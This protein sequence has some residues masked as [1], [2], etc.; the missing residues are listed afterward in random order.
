MSSKF[1][2]GDCSELVLNFWANLSLGILTKFVLIKKACMNLFVDLAEHVLQRVHGQV[3]CV[4]V[5]IAIVL[6][7]KPRGSGGR[8]VKHV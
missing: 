6:L 7:C 4:T 2:S 1:Q 5:A 8:L 3:L